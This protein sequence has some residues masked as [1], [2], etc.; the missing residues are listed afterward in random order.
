MMRVVTSRWKG[1]RS[2]LP[3]I[4]TLMLITFLVSAA[5]PLFAAGGAE[6]VG[7]AEDVRYTAE[8]SG[9]SE[10][11]A[12]LESFFAADARSRRYG[13]VRPDIEDLFRRAVSRDIPV[14]SMNTL[15]REAAAKNVPPGDLVRALDGEL[16]RLTRGQEILRNAGY[17]VAALPDGTLRRISLYMQAGI[18]DPILNELAAAEQEISALLEALET[19]A[20]VLSTS[21]LSDRSAVAL[22]AALM[23]SALSPEAYG[24]VASAYV[25]GRA[26]G[27][28]SRE[29]TDIV[30]RVLEAGGG[31][32]QI[33]REI[34]ARRSS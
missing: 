14:V 16:E 31:I 29:V 8:T 32:I 3:P 1:S 11:T 34:S 9:V 6:D 28:S 13:Q 26:R 33:D 4:L 23:N 19:V 21:A 10:G 27:L 7:E 15:L 30:V 22:G 5:V 12:A 24:S 25:K 20:S 17:Q 2:T 18:S